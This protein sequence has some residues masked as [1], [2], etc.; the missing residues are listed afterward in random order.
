MCK[1]TMQMDKEGYDDVQ[2]KGGWKKWHYGGKFKWWIYKSGHYVEIK[3]WMK[4][5]I[6]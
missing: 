1:L 5:G 6:L 4:K 2:M 3:G